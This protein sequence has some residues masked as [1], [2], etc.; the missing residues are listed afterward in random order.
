[1]APS[2]L[3]ITPIAAT[4]FE[5]LGS[6]YL[7]CSSQCCPF[8]YISVAEWLMFSS[9]LQNIPKWKV[10]VMLSGLILITGSRQTLDCSFSEKL[11]GGIWKFI[12]SHLRP[13]CVLKLDTKPLCEEICYFPRTVWESILTEG[14]KSYQNKENM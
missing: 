12:W 6:F 5:L 7:L 11:I 10:P 3:E 8:V 9:H 4:I 1:M 13:L 14:K 2:K